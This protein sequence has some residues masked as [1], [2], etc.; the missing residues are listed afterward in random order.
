MLFWVFRFVANVISFVKLISFW[1]LR[2]FAENI[3]PNA[4]NEMEIS[5]FSR[6]DE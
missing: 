4:S 5:F 6:L 3:Q 2:N 1:T